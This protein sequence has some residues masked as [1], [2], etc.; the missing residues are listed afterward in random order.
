MSPLT[1]APAASG[2]SCIDMRTNVA[3]APWRHDIS[4]PACSARTPHRRGRCLVLHRPLELYDLRVSTALLVAVAGGAGA[5]IGGTLTAVASYLTTRLQ[6][7][8]QHQVLQLQ[9]H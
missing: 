7:R 8:S 1:F 5:A 9:F 6:L 4:R 3:Q 2:P